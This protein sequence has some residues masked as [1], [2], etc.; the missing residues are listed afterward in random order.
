MLPAAAS[1]HDEDVEAVELPVAEVRAVEQDEFHVGRVP[2]DLRPIDAVG[3]AAS[4]P[5]TGGSNCNNAPGDPVV[6][7]PQSY[8]TTIAGASPRKM[9]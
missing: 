2:E 4:Q 3:A 8:A 6:P 5:V 9:K 7:M 1:G